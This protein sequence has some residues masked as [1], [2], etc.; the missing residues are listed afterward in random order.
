[1]PE[2]TPEPTPEREL[3][4]GALTACLGGPLGV[5]TLPSGMIAGQFLL[6]GGPGGLDPED[7]ITVVAV[8]TLVGFGLGIP[9]GLVGAAVARRVRRCRHAEWSEDRTSFVGPHVAGALSSVI[10]CPVLGFG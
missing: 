10:C 5:V 7:R 6:A 3:K 4:P 9:L 8:L 1:M 2:P